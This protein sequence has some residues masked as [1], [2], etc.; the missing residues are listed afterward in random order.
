M[1]FNFQTEDA[2]RPIHVFLSKS[3]DCVNT[4]TTDGLMVQYQWPIIIKHLILICSF[5][6]DSEGRRRRAA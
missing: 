5:I 1:S 3:C 4:A 2:G 6:I